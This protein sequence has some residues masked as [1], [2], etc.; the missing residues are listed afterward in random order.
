VFKGNFLETEHTLIH[1][2]DEI[3][4]SSLPCKSRRSAWESEGSKSI[5]EKASEVVN[6]I[7]ARPKD[8]YLS[9]TQMEKLDKIQAKWAERLQD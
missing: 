7:L 3:R 5:E 1:Y 6:N 9:G 2:Q 4:Y 8:I